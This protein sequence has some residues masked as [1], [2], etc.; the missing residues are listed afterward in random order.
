[1]ASRGKAGSRFSMAAKKRF[2]SSRADLLH[3]ERRVM[4]GLRE[5][6]T[7]AW[8]SSIQKTR[9]VSEAFSAAVTRASSSD[10]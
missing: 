1:M 8:L 9:H 7:T 5:P 10:L 6:R 4:E 2:H 3:R